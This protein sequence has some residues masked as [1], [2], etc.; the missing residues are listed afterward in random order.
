MFRH[1]QW[2]LTRI[3]IYPEGLMQHKDVKPLAD[4]IFNTIYNRNMS[5]KSLSDPQNERESDQ[6]TLYP[7]NGKRE[8][9]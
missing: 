3:I 8:Y 2:S 7:K 9:A 6:V 1:Y 5:K 4:G